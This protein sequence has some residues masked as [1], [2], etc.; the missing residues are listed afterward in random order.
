M[1][2]LQRLSVHLSPA[3]SQLRD[4]SLVVCGVL[5][6]SAGPAAVVLPRKW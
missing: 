5:G 1:S 6:F 2:F 4:P 3:L